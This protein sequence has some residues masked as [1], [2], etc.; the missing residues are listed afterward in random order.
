MTPWHIERIVSDTGIMKWMHVNTLCLASNKKNHRMNH[1]HKSITFQS[2]AYPSKINLPIP[3]IFLLFFLKKRKILL[4]IIINQKNR[5]KNIEMEWRKHITEIIDLSRVQYI[6][7]YK[8]YI[9]DSVSNHKLKFFF[10]YNNQFIVPSDIP[11]I[12]SFPFQ[13][14]TEFIFLFTNFAVHCKF[15]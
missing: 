2:C 9:L 3:D 15:C 11:S 1:V 12:F 10:G 6:F 4:S 13:V 7:V 5:G 8:Y 14:S